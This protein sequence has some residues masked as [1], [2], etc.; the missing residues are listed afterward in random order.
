MEEAL[1]DFFGRAGYFAVRSVPVT[2]AGFDVTDVDIW[3]YSRSS[4]IARN[5]TVVD[6]K[7]RKTPQAIERIFWAKGLASV[8]G[9]QDVIVATTDKR[10]EVRQ[11]GRLH[12]V[13]V[14]DGTFISKLLTGSLVSDRLGEED[15]LALVSRYEYGR[16]DGDWIGRIKDCKAGLVRGLRF[17]SLNQWLDHFRFFGEQSLIRTGHRE[18]TIRTIYRI[19]AFICIGVDFILSEAAQ[20]TVDERMVEFRDGL[21]FG[22]RGRAAT[23]ELLE[24]AAAM[25]GAARGSQSKGGTRP[26][27]MAEDQMRD[28]RGSILAEYFCRSETMSSLFSLGCRFDDAAMQRSFLDPQQL[29]IEEKA[30]LGVLLDYSMLD[31][32][33]FLAKSQGNAFAAA[34]QQSL[35]E[36]IR[37]SKYTDNE[38]S[39]QPRPAEDT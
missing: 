39:E 17:N 24:L 6:A 4:N 28:Q 16:V 15:Y 25:A 11:Y 12:E 8:I 2:H 7:N 20:Q 1:R 38:A 37:N 10:P 3:L 30:A 26:A 23:R 33:H 35:L 36:S 14:L 29:G 21:D 5:I 18:A 31:R 32:V 19:M 27:R 9:A 34:K 22:D 13:K